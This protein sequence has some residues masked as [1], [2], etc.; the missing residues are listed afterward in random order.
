[1]DWDGGRADGAENLTAHRKRLITNRHA[2]EAV[3][4]DCFYQHAAAI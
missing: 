2:A 1:M 4:P 3:S